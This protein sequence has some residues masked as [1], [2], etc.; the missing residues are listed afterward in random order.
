VPAVCLQQSHSRK[1]GRRQSGGKRI[2]YLFIM[3]VRTTPG[4]VPPTVF[5]PPLLITSVSQLTTAP[6]RRKSSAVAVVQ[7]KPVGKPLR[8]AISEPRCPS[9]P[10]RC[11]FIFTAR[12]AKQTQK[13]MHVAP[14]SRGCK[15][16]CWAECSQVRMQSENKKKLARMRKGPDLG[17]L[18]KKKECF[19]QETLRHFTASPARQPSDQRRRAR[20]PSWTH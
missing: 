3:S 16:V 5:S 15:G 10:A 4:V 14:T 20:G 2:G 17:S 8:A 11:P 1:S 19:A 12:I 13:Q 18:V 9:S 7:S 6:A